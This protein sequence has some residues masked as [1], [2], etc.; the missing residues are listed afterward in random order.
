[1]RIHDIIEVY[2]RHGVTKGNY[3]SNRATAISARRSAAREL[4]ANG[5][6]IV[7]IADFE[8]HHFGGSAYVSTIRYRLG[9]S[10]RYVR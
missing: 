5:L 10:K 9:K 4:Y 8:R 7:D 6:R 2:E 3:R 1:M